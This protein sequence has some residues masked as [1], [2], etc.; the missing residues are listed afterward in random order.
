MAAPPG[1]IKRGLDDEVPVA[2]GLLL[3]LAADAT[4]LVGQPVH[5]GEVELKALIHDRFRSVGTEQPHGGRGSI[6]RDV[7]GFELLEEMRIL[8]VHP[9]GGIHE[10]FGSVV[11]DVHCGSGPVDHGTG[12]VL[13]GDAGTLQLV[14]DDEL[15][16]LQLRDVG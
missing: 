10:L 8:S 5:S 16:G 9:V 4:V 11:T 1:L 6:E 3:V 14:D 15:A 12:P 2:E 13:T 7:P